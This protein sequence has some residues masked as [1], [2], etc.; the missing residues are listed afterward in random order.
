MT[1]KTSSL[2]LPQVVSFLFP[3][4]FALTAMVQPTT[5]V[6]AFL[7]AKMAP[8]ACDVVGPE[9]TYGY[10]LM[11]VLMRNRYVGVS[12]HGDILRQCP[13]DVGLRMILGE[14]GKTERRSFRPGRSTMAFGRVTRDKRPSKLL[15]IGGFQSEPCLS[16]GGC[17][18]IMLLV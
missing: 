8:W 16:A 11:P 1:L 18:R 17:P 2:D 10:I 7:L 13:Y 4:P 14:M 6:C 5:A 12:L 15:A 3:F 9:V